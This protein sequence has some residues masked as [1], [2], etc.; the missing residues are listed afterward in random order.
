MKEAGFDHTDFSE[1]A[2]ENFFSQFGL[3]R[4]PKLV[5]SG[6]GFE[7]H[8]E[9]LTFI[10]LYNPLTGL[11]SGNDTPTKN[12][13]F[14]GYIGLSGDDKKVKKAVQFIMENA[15]HGEYSDERDFI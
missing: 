9:G 10:T 6:L 7:F 4:E 5:G 8:G 14:T 3:S 15:D 12:K 11:R 1:E 2:I 13:G